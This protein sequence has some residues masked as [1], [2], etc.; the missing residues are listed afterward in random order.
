[1]KK[2]LVILKWFILTI[3]LGLFGL[4]TAPIMYPIYY[5]TKC[6]LLWIYDDSKRINPDGTFEEDYRLFL[7]ERQGKQRKHFI[8]V[9]YGWVLGML[10]GI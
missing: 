5:L 6:R 10:F 7:I 9:I 2:L 4:I 8:P 1:M 3:P